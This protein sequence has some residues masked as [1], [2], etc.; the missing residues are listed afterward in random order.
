VLLSKNAEHSTDSGAESRSIVAT[1]WRQVEDRRNSLLFQPYSHHVLESSQ[2]EGSAR[3]F[4]SAKSDERHIHPC[5]G[6]EC[7]NTAVNCRVDDDPDAMPRPTQFKL[8]TTYG[9]RRWSIASSRPQ[10]RG[11]RGEATRQQ[12]FHGRCTNSSSEPVPIT[13]AA[14]DHLPDI[15]LTTHG[16]YFTRYLVVQTN[17]PVSS[18]LPCGEQTRLRKLYYGREH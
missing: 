11:T 13:T 18:C 2:R 17:R 1:K 15:S 10:A 12:V 5:P 4:Q 16:Q 8:P 3:P 6:A 14:D 7:H 9:S